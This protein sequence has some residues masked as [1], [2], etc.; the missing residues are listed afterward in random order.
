MAPLSCGV[1]LQPELSWR[2]VLSLLSGIPRTLCSD[3]QQ[4][5]SEDTE[6][7]T[8]RPTAGAA[9]GK[10]KDDN[11]KKDKTHIYLILKSARLCAGHL[12]APLQVSSTVHLRAPLQVSSTKAQQLHTIIDSQFIPRLKKYVQRLPWRLGG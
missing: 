3:F 10:R 6:G 9:K 1:F 11:D 2:N 12:R 7:V 5:L 8:L 4:V